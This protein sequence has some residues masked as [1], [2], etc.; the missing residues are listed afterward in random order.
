MRQPKN[1][2]TDFPETGCW[3]VKFVFLG[4]FYFMLNWKGNKDISD[5]EYLRY[6]SPFD[7]ES[8]KYSQTT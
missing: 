1:S 2:L 7:I 6:F 8:L 3:R 5:Y 4:T